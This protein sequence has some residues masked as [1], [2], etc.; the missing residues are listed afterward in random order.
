LY[1][2][3]RTTDCEDIRMSFQLLSDSLS[4]NNPFE[5]NAAKH[6]CSTSCNK[7]SV[8]NFQD[9]IKLID[10]E[11]SLLT[12]KDINNLDHG[13]IVL[14]NLDLV[15]WVIIKK[16]FSWENLKNA[17]K[18]L[19]KLNDLCEKKNRWTNENDVQKLFSNNYKGNQFSNGTLSVSSFKFLF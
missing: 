18:P 16:N 10:T 4:N 1:H 2:G 11:T 9:K 8:N 3:H 17:K 7:C 19:R 5:D 12:D 13:S 6:L 15:G 14:G